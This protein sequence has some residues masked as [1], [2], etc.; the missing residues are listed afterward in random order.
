[1]QYPTTDS[2][3]PNHEAAAEEIGF[4]GASRVEPVFISD[5]KEIHAVVDVDVETG[6]VEL[7]D[8]TVLGATES[9]TVGLEPLWDEWV[10]GELLH[11]NREFL[12]VEED[13]YDTEREVAL[14]RPLVADAL[15][16]AR[17][18]LTDMGNADSEGPWTDKV[19]GVVGEFS[20]ALD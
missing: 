12:Y 20:K 2:D 16:V 13:T 1:M 17:S 8:P 3:E 19:R 10:N 6:D 14:D 4:D 9:R 15:E 7:M 18:E 5:G 11:R